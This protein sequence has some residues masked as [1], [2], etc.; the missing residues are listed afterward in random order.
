VHAVRVAA[1]L[2]AMYF[3]MS[4]GVKHRIGA[5]NVAIARRHSYIKTCAARRA[6][7]FTGSEYSLSFVTSL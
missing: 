3:Q 4:F 2:R 6:G 7:E 1:A 5:A